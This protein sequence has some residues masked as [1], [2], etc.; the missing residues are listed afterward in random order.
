MRLRS[1]KEV[2]ARLARLTSGDS[3][4][5]SHG[6]KSSQDVG[7]ITSTSSTSF[8]RFDVHPDRRRLVIESL[9]FQESD[10]SMIENVR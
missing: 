6:S 3:L 9:R 4:Q 2:Y 1:S 10:I 7:S 5:R 8:V